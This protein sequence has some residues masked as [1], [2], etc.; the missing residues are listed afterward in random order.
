[1]G[2][3]LFEAAL[4]YPLTEF[5]P[6]LA[7]QFLE[8]L[9]LLGCEELFELLPETFAQALLLFPPLA[10]E[11]AELFLLL[12]SQV[13]LLAQAFDPAVPACFRWG[14]RRCLLCRYHS[15]GT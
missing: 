8:L 3:A 13:Q 9:P 6:M 15:G 1:M 14:G 7:A 5:F 12:C 11:C 2:R 10:E 4:A